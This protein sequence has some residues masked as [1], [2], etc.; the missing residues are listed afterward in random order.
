MADDSA[1]MDVLDAYKGYNLD[2][3][4]IMKEDD[5]LLISARNNT[6]EAMV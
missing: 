6:L 3:A 4:V 2:E 1:I 5:D